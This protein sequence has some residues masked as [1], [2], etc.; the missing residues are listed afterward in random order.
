MNVASV[1]GRI[2]RA[3]S[4]GYSASKFALIG[5]SDALHPEEKPNGV[6]VGLVLPGFVATEG[7]PQRELME[8]RAHAPDRLDARQGGGRDRGRRPGGKAER[9]VPRAYGL[10]AAAR[11]VTPRL[12]RRALGG[13]G[14]ML[15]PATKADGHE[16]SPQP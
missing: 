8:Q 6:H 16:S 7:F 4:G 14:T 12:V 13:G 3:R 9:Y 2:S 11:V 1:A 5:W 15:T 10:A